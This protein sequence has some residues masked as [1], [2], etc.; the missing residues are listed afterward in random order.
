ME[1]FQQEK[2]KDFLKRL[3]KVIDEKRI[4]FYDQ[5][6]KNR[7][8]LSKLGFT[9]QT[10]L[11]ELKRLQVEDYQRGPEPDEYGTTGSI[12]ILKKEVKG[13][14]LYIKIKDNGDKAPWACISFHEENI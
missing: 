14:K 2:I 7:K 5:K 11:A 10:V 3:S 9:S 4:R 6:G 12:W 1:K 8:T 13:I